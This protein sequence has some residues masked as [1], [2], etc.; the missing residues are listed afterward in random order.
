MFNYGLNTRPFQH[1]ARPVALRADRIAAAQTRLHLVPECNPRSETDYTIIDDADESDVFTITGKKFGDRPGREFRD[2]SG[3]PLYELHQRAIPLKQP[4]S[5]RLPGGDS[6]SLVST[7]LWPSLRGYRSVSCEF[8][9]QNAAA[10]DNK[11][12]HEKSV[13]LH[14]QRR[15]SRLYAFDV[16][17]GDRKIIEV[18]ESI[19][20]N[21]K[22]AL[23]P[24]SRKDYHPILDIRVAPGVDLVLAA[25]IAVILSDWMYGP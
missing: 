15:P 18:Q 23:M 19:S 1:P 9:F 25:L 11:Q 16:L 6:D 2:A 8:K 13:K 4:W 20:K 7:Q 14:T 12:P 17:D 3:L 10:I 24:E 22:L 21:D 5:V